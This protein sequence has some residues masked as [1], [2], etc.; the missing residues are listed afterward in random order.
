[1]SLPA[2]SGY[3]TLTQGT[4]PVGFSATGLDYGYAYVSEMTQ[5]GVAYQKNN[6]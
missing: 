3:L 2:G 6:P 5:T 4:K 1:M